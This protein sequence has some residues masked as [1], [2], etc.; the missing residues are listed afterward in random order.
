MCQWN[1]R[2]T[3]WVHVL[4][5]HMWTLLSSTY[6]EKPVTPTPQPPTPP[7]PPPQNK[8]RKN[9][10]RKQKA[11]RLIRSSTGIVSKLISQKEIGLQSI[12]V[13]SREANLLGTPQGE[14]LWFWLRDIYSHDSWVGSSEIWKQVKYPHFSS[15]QCAKKLVSLGY[16]YLQLHSEAKPLQV[17][18]AYNHMDIQ[19]VA[20]PSQK[21][22]QHPVILAYVV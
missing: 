16:S 1:V 18:L 11:W 14:Q 2:K 19:H 17:S 12:S 6:K 20:A 8:K 10:D 5:E 7:S 22:T 15:S 9:T 21:T 4:H 13:S 3:W